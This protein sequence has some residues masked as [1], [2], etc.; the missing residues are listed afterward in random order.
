MLGTEF[1]KRDY[2]LRPE[3]HVYL[4]LTTTQRMEVI[5]SIPILTNKE[6]QAER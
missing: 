3:F 1:H 5:L 2:V 4:I 6:T